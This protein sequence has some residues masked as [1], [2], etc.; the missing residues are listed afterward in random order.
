LEKGRGVESER[1]N[2]T[3]K[4]GYIKEGEIKEKKES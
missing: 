4:E 1:Q 2:P 3:M